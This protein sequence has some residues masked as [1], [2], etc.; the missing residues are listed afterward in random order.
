MVL[1]FEEIDSSDFSKFATGLGETGGNGVGGDGRRC[2]SSLVSRG[3]RGDGDEFQ[4]RETNFSSGV[5]QSDKNK[6]E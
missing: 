3:D 6:G 2:L 1:T 4:A 5:K